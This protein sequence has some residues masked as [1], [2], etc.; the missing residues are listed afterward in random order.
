VSPSP[1]SKVVVTWTGL[2][3]PINQRFE[4]D[5]ELRGVEL[6]I[7][8]DR[9]EILRQLGDA[10]VAF[11]APFDAEMLSAAKRLRWVHAH[12]GGVE[13]YLFPEMVAS[14]IPFT[15]IKSTFATVGREFAIAAMLLF[16]RRLNHV[17]GTEALSVE[18]Q[19]RD[20]ELHPEDLAGRTVGV[21]GMGNMGTAIAQGAAS[22]GMRVLALART[23]RPTPQQVD[24]LYTVE[25][26]DSFLPQCDYVVTALPVTDRT[27]GWIDQALLRKMKRTAYLIDCSGRLAL[28]DFGALVGAIEDERIAG[29]CLQ[30]SGPARSP[31]IPAASSAFWQRVNVVVSPCRGTS[32]EQDEICLELFFDN[33]NRYR[34]GQPLRDL[35]DKHAGY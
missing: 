15:C 10:E 17:I 11:V 27:R 20:H 6:F 34:T 32:V 9:D 26:I 16:S 2:K 35:V 30:P 4:Q 21:L 25:D 18:V 23:P 14:P 5:A 7:G 28:Y 3:G 24:H 22:M 33:L 1:L 31:D 12:V 13:N 19:S 29:I 8:D